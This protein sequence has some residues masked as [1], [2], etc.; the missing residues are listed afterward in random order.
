MVPANPEGSLLYVDDV[1]VDAVGSA[2]ATPTISLSRDASGI[3]I[4]F[5][6]VLQSASEIKGPWAPVA[7]ASSPY[8][9]TPTQARAFYQS[10]R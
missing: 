7:G 4:T 8:T 1:V 9:V 3:K 6:G 2:S 5:D 10:T